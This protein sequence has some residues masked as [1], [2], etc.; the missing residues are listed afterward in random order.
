M[1][2]RPH[3]LKRNDTIGITATARSVKPEDM[4]PAIDVLQSWGLKV[5]VSEHLYDV[6]GQFAGEDKVRMLAL[7]NMIDDPEIKAIACARGGYGTTRI[8]DDIDFSSLLKNPKWIVGFSDITVLL[9]QLYTIGIE[10]I[11]GVMPGLFHKAGMEESIESLRR[12]LFGESIVMNAPHHL[13]NR[14]GAASGPVVG[15]NLSIVNNIIGTVSDI[16]TTDKI[17]FIE[18]LD[19]YL[20]H[21]DRMMVHLKRA[22]KLQNLKGLV[23]GGMSDMNDNPT[24]FGKSAYEIIQEHVAACQYPVCFGMPIGHEVR[25]LAIPFGRTGSLKVDTFGAQLIFTE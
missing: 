22:G 13:L 17:L 11:H 19:E 21:I 6:Y 2:K 1:I 16:D 25:N 3:Y 24:P 7:Q 4:A 10:S 20:Y 8:I 5:V 9:Y 15:G 14:P 23:V 18:D 12:V